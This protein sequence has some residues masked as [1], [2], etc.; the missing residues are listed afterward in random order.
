MILY[1][2]HGGIHYILTQVSYCADNLS[3]SQ[4][5]WQVLNQLLSTHH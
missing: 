1:N 4:W 2:L 5:P 3:Y